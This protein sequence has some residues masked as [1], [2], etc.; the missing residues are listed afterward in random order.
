MIL[1]HLASGKHFSW[2]LLKFKRV[3]KHYRI[4]FTLLF[5]RLTFFLRHFNNDCTQTCTQL[6]ISYEMDWYRRHLFWNYCSMIETKHILCILFIVILLYYVF[7]IILLYLSKRSDI[8]Q[9]IEQ[10]CAIC[11]SPTSRRKIN[12]VSDTSRV[13]NC[14]FG[15]WGIPQRII[16]H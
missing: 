4:F 8:F 16:R 12:I 5:W 10:R 14:C 2:K 1:H 6:L 9:V 11:T 7:Y 13:E 15:R 3:W